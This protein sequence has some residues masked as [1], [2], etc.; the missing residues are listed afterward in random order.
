[1]NPDYLA[2]VINDYDC[3]GLVN[4]HSFSCE[5][6]EIEGDN[7]GT[8]LDGS[9]IKDI[10]AVKRR[11]SWTLNTI[12]AER[13]AAFNDALEDGE[14]LNRVSAI[15][16]DSL[17]NR[18]CVGDFY[19]TRPAFQLS[20]IVNG[21]TRSRAG[22]ALI[23][24]QQGA[25]SWFIVTPP[26]TLSYEVGDAFD[27]TG[28][29][30]TLSDGNGNDTDITSECTLS[31]SDG[32]ELAQSGEIS[33]SVTY[34]NRPVGAFALSVSVA[35]VI[36]NGDWWTLYR[37]G[38]LVISCIGDMP[39]SEWRNYKNIIT[40]V[41]IRDGAS[42]IKNSAFYNCTKLTSVTIPN[43]VTSIEAAVFFGCSNLAS[44]T[45]P[46]SVTSIGSSAFQGCSNFAS[47]I[48]PNSITKI[49]GNSFYS[50]S[51]LASVTIPDSV[52]SIEYEAFLYTALTSVTISRNCTLGTNAFPDNC[53]I[54]YYEDEEAAP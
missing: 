25:L 32:A 2:P 45:I 43:S 17:R 47:I 34:H 38:R 44:V 53:V 49:E 51:N 40:R 1:M 12:N 22:P 23:L 41:V 10:L 27:T 3:A 13:Y 39:E 6:F 29:S 48:I 42:S 14:F 35:E 50:C 24:E 37:S 8:L 16:F 30:V 4:R 7:G 21:V 54:N 33:V 52:I 11:F 28:F 31:V 36:A 18:Y 19:I 5:P 46:N 9:T 20:L 26:D 15:V